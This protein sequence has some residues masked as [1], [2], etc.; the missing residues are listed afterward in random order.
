MKARLVR[1]VVGVSIAYLVTMFRAPLLPG[2]P[3]RPTPVGVLHFF[4]GPSG[5]ITGGYVEMNQP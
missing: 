5:D 1:L 2:P 3:P 4:I